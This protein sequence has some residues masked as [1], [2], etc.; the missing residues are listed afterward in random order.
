MTTM[1][2]VFARKSLRPSSKSIIDSNALACMVTRKRILIGLSVLAVLLLLAIPV[3]QPLKFRYAIWRI[4]SAATP[5]QERSACMLARC[6]GHVWEVNS[7][8]RNEFSVLPSRVKPGTNEM[9][10]EIEWWESPWWKDMGAPYRAYRV[11]L[12][13]KNRKFLVAK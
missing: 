13:P 11:L 9:V 10:T 7:I 6:V 8:H 4:E 5:E 3:Y 1:T 2:Q 12:D